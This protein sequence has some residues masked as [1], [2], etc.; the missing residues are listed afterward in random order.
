MTQINAGLYDDV[1]EAERTVKDLVGHGFPHQDISLITADSGGDYARY[2][3]GQRT[4]TLAAE[5]AGAG[6]VIGGV[7]G[8]GGGVGAL[9]NPGIRPGI[10]AGGPLSVGRGGAGGFYRG[11]AGCARR[12]RGLRTQRR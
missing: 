8:L 10:A 5:A 6:A 7:G 3:G 1:Q 4:G 12:L 9:T 11:G 2:I